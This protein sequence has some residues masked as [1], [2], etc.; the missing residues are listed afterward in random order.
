MSSLTCMVVSAL[1]LVAVAEPAR[2]TTGGGSPVSAVDVPLGDRITL[3]SGRELRGVKVLHSTSFKLVLEVIP[4]VAPLEIP[5]RQVVRIDYG[6][7]PNPEKPTGGADS[8]PATAPGPQ[9][10]EAVKVSPELA[11][12]LHAPVVNAPLDFQDQGVVN[13]LR[14]VAILGE[15]EVSFG[16]AFTEPGS[17]PETRLTVTLAAG[18]SFD[19]F[20]REAIHPKVPALTVEYRFQSIHFDVAE[21]AP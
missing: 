21:A 5:L 4:T 16:P 10:L 11:E 19:A 15:I 8:A 2:E 7:H 1:Y 14:S 17:E 20:L 9:V 12:K 6:R 13:I 18:Q 3:K